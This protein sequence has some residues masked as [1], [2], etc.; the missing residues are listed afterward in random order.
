MEIPQN[1]LDRLV[2]FEHARKLCEDSYTV[3][4]LDADNLT[5]WG[6]ALLELSQYQ[7]VSDSKKMIKVDDMD[8]GYNVFVLFHVDAILKLEEALLIN[9]ERHDTLWCLGNAHTSHAFLT[10]DH[11]VAKGYFDRA[12]SY[13]EE[14]VE[15]DPT[16]E[17]Y[18]K[19]L[20]VTS[21]AP[22]LH[23]EVHKHGFGEQLAGGGASS[24]ST[25]KAPKKK[26]NSDLT[27]D[28]F[29]WV[30]LTV[31]IFAWVGMTRSHPPPPVTR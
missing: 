6:G 14:A 1:D 21:K 17:I 20:A 31:G 27:Y 10:P 30:I 22:E 25:K 15:G 24:T 4:P 16:N 12:T 18:L 29:G 11:S 26:K 2:F 19:S 23:M 9:P 3:N 13:F 5:R 7:N 8:N 28:I